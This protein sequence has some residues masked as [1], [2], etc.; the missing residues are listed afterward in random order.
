[1]NRIKKFSSLF[2]LVALAS[3]DDFFNRYDPVEEAGYVFDFESFVFESYNNTAFYLDS[4]GNID[5]DNKKISFTV[6]PSLDFTA[7]HTASFA[8]SNRGLGTS[9]YNYITL[10]NRYWQ[11]SQNM[12]L[13]KDFVGYTGTEDTY[14]DLTYEI[15]LNRGLTSHFYGS[16][17]YTINTSPYRI[18]KTATPYITLEFNDFISNSTLTVEDFTSNYPLA[19]ITYPSMEDRIF[20][21]DPSG[22][23]SEG[24]YF[25][26]LNGGS[27]EA[28]TSGYYNQPSAPY[29]FLCD[30]T[31]PAISD[32]T[33]DD[34]GS[35]WIPAVAQDFVLN[36]S[37]S[38]ASDSRAASSDLRYKI[39]YSTVALNDVSDVNV[40]YYSYNYIP[41][42]GQEWFPYSGSLSFSYGQLPYYFQVNMVDNTVYFIN[43]LVKEFDDVMDRCSLYSPL[44]RT[45]EVP[46][47]VI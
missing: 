39:V 35:D 24:E 2:L 47:P 22:S 29:T 15:N 4:Y 32:I 37:F 14:Y 46:D 44:Q 18:F 1:M 45:Y 28:G 36:L 16:P 5:R 27:C 41:V 3:C 8:V 34:T 10:S 7:P 43:I 30:Y 19:A 13:T 42:G 26:S 9:F 12:T 20:S 31:A 21:I 6:P 33:V 23:L 40:M 38:E 25:L 17:D 11:S